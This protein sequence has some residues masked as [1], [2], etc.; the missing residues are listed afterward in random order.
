L[1]EI[2]SII[3]GVA[4]FTAP[5]LIAKFAT[6]LPAGIVTDAGTEATVTLLLESSTINPPAG[7]LIDEATV[8]VDVLPLTGLFGFM[9]KEPSAATASMV[10]VALAVPL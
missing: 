10:R 4:L 8:T 7:A 3:T 6:V 2:A 9:V 5:K 1:A